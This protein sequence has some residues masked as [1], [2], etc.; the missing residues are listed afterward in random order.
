M[1]AN[2]CSPKTKY[3]MTCNRS[4]VRTIALH[5]LIKKT[6]LA[7]VRTCK[8]LQ[9]KNK[10]WDD[11]QSFART[12][13]CTP[14]IKNKKKGLQLFVR[15]NDCSPKTKIWDDLQL[16][17]CTNNCTPQI[18]FEKGLQSFV[19]VN[20]C[21]PKTNYEMTC[22]RSHVQTIALHKLKIKKTWLAIVRMCERLQSTNKI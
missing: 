20:N 9:S 18:C 5:K 6:W 13:D 17:A 7:I 14:K 19:C 22:N 10:I 3:E 4:H 21:S 15:A 8:R 11:L 2:D 12:N 16:F 1:R